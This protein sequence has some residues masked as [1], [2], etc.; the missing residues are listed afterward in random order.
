MQP[1]AVQEM[2]KAMQ[3]MV[4][5]IRQTIKVPH[6]TFPQE[7]SEGAEVGDMTNDITTRGTIARVELGN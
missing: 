2:V 1:F 7:I 3:T 6:M 5:A 4:H